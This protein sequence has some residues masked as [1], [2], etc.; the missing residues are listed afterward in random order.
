MYNKGGKLRTEERL[1][2]N[3]KS[4]NKDNHIKKWMWKLWINLDNVNNKLVYNNKIKITVKNTIKLLINTQKQFKIIN[5]TSTGVEN[6][7]YY[8]ESSS[9]RDSVLLLFF[10]EVFFSRNALHKNPKLNILWRFWKVLFIL[11]YITLV[12]KMSKAINK[13]LVK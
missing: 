9:M 3:K 13:F 12:P 5:L 10:S 11:T 8:F 1:P 6:T 7:F 4:Q 2:N